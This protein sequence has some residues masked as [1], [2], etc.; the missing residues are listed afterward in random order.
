MRIH[1]EAGGQTEDR[2]GEELLLLLTGPQ[3][4]RQLQHTALFVLR[5]STLRA[6]TGK[7]QEPINN[8]LNIT[9]S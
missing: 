9:K 4:V 3:F 6:K 5:Y 7:M 2:F 8:Q 1:D